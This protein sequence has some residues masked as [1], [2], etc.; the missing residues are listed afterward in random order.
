MTY[1]FEIEETEK[2][3]P[4]IQHLKSLKYVKAKKIPAPRKVW[5][6]AE[7]VK[8]VKLAEKSKSIPWEEFK[9]ESKTW[10][11]KFTK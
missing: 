6:E 1:S 9:R 11:N 3:L 10:K 5:T 8:A 2:T 4:L 7:M